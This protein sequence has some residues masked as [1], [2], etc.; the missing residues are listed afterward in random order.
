MTKFKL[1]AMALF[2]SSISFGQELYDIDNITEIRITFTDTDWD[3]TM[4]TYYANDLDELLYG[5]CEI[6]GEMY[7]SVGVSYKGNST[8]NASNIKNPLKIKLADIYD[9]QAYQGYETLKLSSGKNDPSFVREVLSYEIGRQYMDMPLSNYAKVYIND[10]FYGVFSSSE[11]INKDYM[12][13]H[14]YIDRDNTRIKCNPESVFGGNGSSMEYLGADSSAYFD[15]YELKSDL[16]WNALVDYTNTLENDFSNIENV[17]DVDRAIWMLAFNNVLVNLDSYTGPFRQNYYLIE[18]DHGRMLPIIWDL[19][20]CIGGFE[21]VNSGGGPPGGLTDLTEMD[22]YIRENDNTFPL[23][24]Q[25]FSNPRYKKM[26]LAHVKTMVEENLTSGDYYSRAE[27]LQ[28][29]I[30]SEVQADPNALYTYTE[31][32]NNLDNQ[33]GSGPNGSYGVDEVL[34]DRETYIT[35]LADYALVAPTI[36]N[37]APSNITPDANSMVTITAD[38]S[39]ATFAHLGY[40]F[41]KADPFQKLEMFDD[42]LHNDG[43]ASDGVYGIDVTLIAADMQYYIYADNADAGK[44]SPVR[45]EHEFY[46]LTVSNSV[47]INEIMPSNNITASDQDG[48]FDDWIELYN[49]TASDVDLSGYFLTD[50]ELILNKWI[51]PTGTSIG[52]NDYLIVWCD[53]DVTQ[54]GLHAGFKLTSNGE[55]LIL[56]DAT[57]NPITEVTFP[58]VTDNHTYGRYVNGTGGYIPMVATH[59]A[60]NSFTALELDQGISTSSFAL[61][62]NPAT[63]V[64]TLVF[65]GDQTQVDIIDLSGKVLK[66]TQLLSGSNFDV[67]DLS[68]GIYLVRIAGVDDVKKLIVR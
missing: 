56:S 44:F 39:D 23:I 62:P 63:D 52:A 18:D 58:E 12:Q 3:A 7:D 60:E 5:S 2:L 42:G 57:M 37:V 28:T 47:V 21:M 51:F 14:F 29:I 68:A 31:F 59:A 11:S 46:E 41:Y 67:S 10:D 9:F 48:E 34:A 43:A 19:N 49:N 22:I 36:S 20:E 17:L 24:S 55:T 50:D 38:I 66:S 8:Y 30:D 1:A 25:L 65:D 33:V 15:F 53:N 40:R 6:N 54:T 13:D 32:T 45:A 35:A 27:E 4:D 61:Y 26:Y 16:G 64:V